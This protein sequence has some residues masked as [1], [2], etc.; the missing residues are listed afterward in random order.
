[1]SQRKC[2]DLWLCNGIFSEILEHPSPFFSD[3]TKD[4]I[5]PFVLIVLPNTKL[6]IYNA[7]NNF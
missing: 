1:M 5:S 7:L 4:S 3:D 6:V 2:A